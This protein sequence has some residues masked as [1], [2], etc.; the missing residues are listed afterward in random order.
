MDADTPR[1]TT[2]LYMVVFGLGFG[3]VSQVLALA[4]QN[5]VERSDIG[6]ATGSANL[7][8]ALGG[9]VGVALFGAIF[10]ARARHVAAALGAVGPGGV[11]AQSL[12]AGPEAI[13]RARRRPRRDRGGGLALA[14]TVFLVATPIALLG[15]AVVLLLAEVPLRGP[16]ARRREKPSRRAGGAPHDRGGR[17]R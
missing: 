14:P 10:A 6:I 12:Q 15:V 9:S 7:F 4:I 5:A 1:A 17:T 3:M 8:R 2:A 13:A 11:D 16:A